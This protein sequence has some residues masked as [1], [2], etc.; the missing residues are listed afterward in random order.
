VSIAK[1]RPRDQKYAIKSFI[2]KNGKEPTQYII[3]KFKEKDI[4]IL[5]EFNRLKHE[6]QFVKSLIPKMYFNGIYTLAMEFGNKED[7]SKVDNLL[8]KEFYNEDL[9]LGILRNFTEYGI[10]GYQEYLDIFKEAWRMNQGLTTNAPRFRIVLLSSSTISSPTNLFG[11]VNILN[12]NKIMAEVIEKEIINKGKKALIFITSSHSEYCTLSFKALNIET[13]EK[14]IKSSMLTGIL[15]KKYPNKVFAVLFHSPWTV[16]DKQSSKLK[17]LVKPLEGEIDGALELIGNNPVA[18]DI[19]GSPMEKLAD[20]MSVY[21]YL[22]NEYTL[23]CLCDGYIY[24]K[25]YQEYEY[26]SWIPEFIDENYLWVV[27]EYFKKVNPDLPMETIGYASDFC[28]AIGRNLFEL[29][30]SIKSSDYVQSSYGN[31]GRDN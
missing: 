3:D 27:K 12:K 18:F 24:L 6:V 17:G 16:V 15:S 30:K 8:N 1:V 29:A 5:S 28:S 20:K 21:Y 14:D 2:D 9:A 25:T 26:V 31:F 22:N 13:R 23:S 11:S 19:A 4:V 10:W 7:Q